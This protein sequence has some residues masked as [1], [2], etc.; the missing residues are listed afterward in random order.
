MDCTACKA[1]GKRNSNLYYGYCITCFQT[2]KMEEDKN[3][4]DSGDYID[5]VKGSV[6]MEELLIRS[7]KISERD[8]YGSNRN[9]GNKVEK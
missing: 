6:P 5:L 7:A 1:C 8:Y 9:R 4:D 3:V 2:V